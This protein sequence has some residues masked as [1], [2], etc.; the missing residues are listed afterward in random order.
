MAQGSK[1]E[2]EKVR[3]IIIKRIKKGGHG[4]HGGAW[5]VA[6]ADF[7][8]AMMAF[9]LLMW[10]LNVTTKEQKNAISDIFDPSH[11]LISESQSGAG[12]VMGGTTI[13][14][15]GAQTSTVQPLTQQPPDQTTRGA[16]QGDKTEGKEGQT[17]QPEGVTQEDLT[18]TDP[19]ALSAEA[20]RAALERREQASFKDAEAKIRAAIQADPA[21]E[22]LDGNTLI[23]ITPEGLRIQ[24]VDDKGR[25][26]FP[27]GSAE[28]Y[29]FMRALLVKVTSITK[30]LP[31]QI[32]VRG[33]TDAAPFR[34]GKSYDNWNLSADRA[35]ATRRVMIEA[36]LPEARIES[37]IGRAAREPLLPDD[38]L[39]PRNRRMTIV[40]LRDV[41]DKIKPAAKP[42]VPVTPKVP[43]KVK[44]SLEIIDDTKP[45][46]VPALP[47]P[48]TQP[49]L[50]PKVNAEANGLE[51]TSDRPLPVAP[52]TEPTP[53]KSDTLLFDDAPAQP[54]PAP[55]PPED[56]PV[57]DGKTLTF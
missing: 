38:V 10:L 11:P 44:S 55:V 51:T 16:D 7:V 40:L 21:L 26:M 19:D 12:G 1:S 50:A 15:E 13:A 32:S 33:H 25:S 4:H 46:P 18:E 43:E 20:L 30:A 56:E 37:V 9:F 3:P 49:V 47:T 36:G 14:V 23:D 29:D 22:P 6:Y 54:V 35:Q 17:N 28:M 42:D 52:R 41:P 24:I 31:N 27:S 48:K 53:L 2:N 8:T 39:S 57:G 34:N 5:K 45:N